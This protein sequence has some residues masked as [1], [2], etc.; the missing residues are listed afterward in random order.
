VIRARFADARFFYREDVKK[1]LEAYLE[2]LQTLTF[3]EKLGSY[4]EKVARLEGLAA[5]IGALL[6]LND[7]DLDRTIRA[8]R[9][10]KADLATQM[11]VEMTSLQGV[12]GRE[13]AL[14]SG[15][16]PA[17]AVAL[18]EHYL[19]RFAG[20][21]VPQSGS[22]IAV[23]LADRLDSLIGLF[24]VGLAPTG[25]S[26]PYGLRRAALGLVQITLA[27][28]LD[29]DLRQLLE[30]AAQG[31]TGALGEAFITVET[32][33]TVLE[34]ISGRLEVA[35]REDYAHDVTAA[36]LAAQGHNPTRARLHAEQ[37]TRR[38]QAP[39]WA[40]TL[41]AFAR[42][43]RITRN[44][45]ATCTVNPAA[46][47]KPVEPQLY[48]AYETAAQQITGGA[49]VDTMLNAFEPLVPLITTFFDSEAAG[50]VL[51]MHPDAAVR[52]TRLAQLQAIVSLARG[53]A[54]FSKL[55]GF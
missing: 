28:S 19:P 38:V 42:C 31:Y 34:F 24:S 44:Q 1:P 51:V 45:A 30:W 36:V 54:D 17:V 5:R 4:R 8:A 41:D 49:D 14:L 53:V 13:Y 32:Q 23:A 20:D 18:A 47:E 3:Q 26:D 15:E 12:I 46:F 22:G 50:G 2:G 48:A 39:G 16:D 21:A 37:L 27:H 29:L 52:E 33:Q 55:E 25:T 40:A 43:A 35:L 10:A 6:G 9:L 7:A 11:V